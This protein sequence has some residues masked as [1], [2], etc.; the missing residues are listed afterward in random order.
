MVIMFL[1][2]KVSVCDCCYVFNASCCLIN[3]VANNGSGWL[4]VCILLSLFFLKNKHLCHGG[5]DL[6]IASLV[7]ITVVTVTVVTVTVVTVAV[8]TDTV[9]C[10]TLA[11]FL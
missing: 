1:M 9:L 6:V 7:K 2:G 8:V 10:F 11:Y 4:C 3:S 5:A